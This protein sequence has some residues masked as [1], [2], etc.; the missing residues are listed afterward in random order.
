MRGANELRV[1]LRSATALYIRSTFGHFLRPKVAVFEPLSTH[2][3]FDL[4][5]VGDGC[6]RRPRIS[7]KHLPHPNLVI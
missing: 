7:L 5:A 6:L 4:P 1:L 2:R 3:S